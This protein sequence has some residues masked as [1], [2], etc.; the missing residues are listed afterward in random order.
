[1]SQAA[2]SILH[3]CLSWGKRLLFI[4]MLLL[5]LRV[6]ECNCK[7][8][9]LLQFE[10]FVCIYYYFGERGGWPKNFLFKNC[11]C[12]NLVLKFSPS[13]CQFSHGVYFIHDKFWLILVQCMLFHS[14]R[15]C[16]NSLQVIFCCL[17]KCLKCF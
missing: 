5:L 7:P 2:L 10:K 14:L 15:L 17:C 12:W 8:Q 4:L 9:N 3:P 16:V 1:M 13:F 11:N 6:I